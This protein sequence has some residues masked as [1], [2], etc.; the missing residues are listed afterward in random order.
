[1]IFIQRV[2]RTKH[3]AIVAA[4]PW[5]ALEKR[6]ETFWSHPPREMRVLLSSLVAQ[7]NGEPVRSWI[8]RHSHLIL[9]I[10]PILSGLS[11][12]SAIDVTTRGGR[13]NLAGHN[14]SDWHLQSWA[15]ASVA[16]LDPSAARAI[17]QMNQGHV[18]GRLSKM[19]GIDVEEFVDFLKVAR[20][21]DRK[22]FLDVL[23][24]VDIQSAHEKW[25]RVL[26]DERPEIRKGAT[27]TLR[28][29]LE[30]GEGAAR[31]LA[32]TVLN[33]GTPRPR[34]AGSSRRGARGQSEV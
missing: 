18:V 20:N 9:E 22:W 31:D 21:L 34:R 12:Q 3:G 32:D 23:R 6:C 19:E 11:P 25:Q 13:V 1:L 7:R 2:N 16:K 14:E 15:L 29:I 30:E 5:E 17:L 24:Q 4:V 8:L 28:F 26:N 33:A 27:R 10:D